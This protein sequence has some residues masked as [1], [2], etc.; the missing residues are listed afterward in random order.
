[1]RKL[2]INGIESNCYLV[3]EDGEVFNIEGK[4]LAKYR[5]NVG[6][7]RVRLN[8]DIP[9]ALYSV[10][11]IVAETYLENP[12]NYPIALHIN[13][14]RHD[15]RVSNLKWGTNSENQLQRFKGGYEGT[16]RKV[17]YQLELDT[18]KLVKEYPSPIEAFKETG[19]ANQNISKVCRGLRNKAGGYYWTYNKEE[20][21]K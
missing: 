1:M 8:R 3:S 15:C 19:I 6:Y 18:Y 14:V 2:K 20:I 5:T 16:K 12:N 11:R 10:H 13:D 21:K 9:R 4:K 17:V 7:D